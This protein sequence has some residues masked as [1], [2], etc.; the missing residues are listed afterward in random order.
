MYSDSFSLNA[1]K[2]GVVLL[3]HEFLQVIKCYPTLFEDLNN[4]CEINEI[5]QVEKTMNL[6]FPS[7]LRSVYLSN[8]GQKGSQDGIFK[9]VSGYNK[10]S[11]PKL[12]DTKSIVTV[13]RTLSEKTY[14]NVFKASYIPF[15]ADNIESADDVYCIDSNTGEVFLLWVLIYDPFNPIEWQINKFLKAS[16]LKGFLSYQIAL[17]N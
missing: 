5:E 15:A 16:S 4:G 17:Y 2:I 3:W 10:Y 1:V 12:L 7:D 13:W 9:A 11:R 6:S 8:N 14:T